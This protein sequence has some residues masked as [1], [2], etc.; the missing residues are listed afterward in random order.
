M[1]LMDD[2]NSCTVIDLSIT[3]LTQV[4]I[5]SC[6]IVLHMMDIPSG[7]AELKDMDDRALNHFALL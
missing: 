3:S 5:I 4:R 7:I 1:K 2:G 6:S